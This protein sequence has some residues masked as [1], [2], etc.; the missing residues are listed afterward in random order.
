MVTDVQPFY[1]MKMFS[2]A[3]LYFLGFL[4]ATDHRVLTCFKAWLKNLFPITFSTSLPLLSTKKPICECHF[5]NF[6]FKLTR[7]ENLFARNVKRRLQLLQHRPG[8]LNLLAASSKA[9][10]RMQS[11]ISY[12]F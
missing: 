6:G 1:L 11:P 7:E 12:H 4:S 3:I 5:L 9:K 10:D 2:H 8:C